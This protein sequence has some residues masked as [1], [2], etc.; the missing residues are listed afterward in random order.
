MSG[1]LFPPTFL[2]P[3]FLPAAAMAAAQSWARHFGAC[4]GCGHG[5]GAVD[6]CEAEEA[7][8]AAGGGG[9]TTAFPAAGAAA[10]ARAGASR[11]LV[12]AGVG[13][14][15]SPS[16]PAREAAAPE[17]RRGR[18]KDG[19]DLEGSVVSVSTNAGA[20]VE[21]A[22]VGSR[23]CSSSSRAPTR[24]SWWQLADVGSIPGFEGVEE[25]SR[26]LEARVE[27]GRRGLVQHGQCE[28]VYRAIAGAPKRGSR[29]RAGAADS[30][31][32][33]GPTW[34]AGCTSAT[35]RW[36]SRPRPRTSPGWRPPSLR[37]R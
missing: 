29:T 21:E 27:R 2:V 6:G 4:I 10:A 13:A 22:S 17:A 12:A 3:P 1:L 34:S 5:A 19:S 8:C 26:L 31:D 7:L 33:T 16:A 24:A 15:A 36:C 20:D 18:S 32:C 25:V 37:T 9:Y 28:E 14:S 11:G 30:E 23:S 35:S